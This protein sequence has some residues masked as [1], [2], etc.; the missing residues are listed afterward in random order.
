MATK[1]TVTSD[2]TIHVTESDIIRTISDTTNIRIREKVLSNK[3]RGDDTVSMVSGYSLK[4][5]D[6][7]Y[8]ACMRIWS[9]YTKMIR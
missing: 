5:V 4:S 3:A 1:Q 2:F 8:K 7:P 6:S 9:A